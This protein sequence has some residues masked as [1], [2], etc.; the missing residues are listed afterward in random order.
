MTLRGKFHTVHPRRHIDV[1]EEH[2]NIAGCLKA[3]ESRLGI[4]GLDDV[5]ACLVQNIGYKH[6]DEHLVVH[7]QHFLAASWLFHSRRTQGW[8][9]RSCSTPTLSV[10]VPAPAPHSSTRLSGR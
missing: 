6:A 7:H 9:L 10:P 8:S 1:G 3:F 4:A 5:K 2:L